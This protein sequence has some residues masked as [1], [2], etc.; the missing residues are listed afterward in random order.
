MRRLL[1]VLSLTVASANGAMAMS[2]T[3]YLDRAPGGCFERE[4]AAEADRE[5]REKQAREFAHRMDL[6]P[7]TAVPA[8][9]KG[10][11]SVY[12]P[13]AQMLA[14]VDAADAWDQQERKKAEARDK[15]KPPQRWKRV[16]ADNGAVFGIDPACGACQRGERGVTAAT[17]EVDGGFCV[18]GSERLVYF[19]CRG[20]YQD[21]T[22]FASGAS[23]AHIAPPRSV[24]GR[25]AE[26][27]CGKHQPIPPAAA[28]SGQSQ[29]VLGKYEVKDRALP[30][31]S[32]K[33]R[34]LELRDLPVESDFK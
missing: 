22:S 24:I 13:P 5:Q 27:A 10:G 1:L 21:V 20:H 18:R 6:V 33:A 11:S 14:C 28:N 16:E 30:W 26:I 32:T 3:C 15:A 19:D 29:K 17:C 8:F 9:C 2:G 23:G 12:L 4:T 7:S 31:P 34:D 25:M